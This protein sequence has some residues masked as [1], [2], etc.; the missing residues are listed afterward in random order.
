MS[1]G[2]YV[3]FRIKSKYLLRDNL[4]QHTEDKKILKIKNMVDLELL[5]SLLYLDKI[6]R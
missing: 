6:F 2:L 5:Y 3:K 1:H 4:E